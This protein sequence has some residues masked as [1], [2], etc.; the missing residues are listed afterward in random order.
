MNAQTAS[1][2]GELHAAD[3]APTRLQARYGRPEER[4]VGAGQILVQAPK[5]R[6]ELRSPAAIGPV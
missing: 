1:Q 6:A 5:I 2:E 4:Q 3:R